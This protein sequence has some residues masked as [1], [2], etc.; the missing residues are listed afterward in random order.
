VQL[1]QPAH[2]DQLA[3]RV[4]LE[5]LEIQVQLDPRDELVHRAH[6]QV[7]QDFEVMHTFTFSHANTYIMFCHVSVCVC[8]KLFA[9]DSLGYSIK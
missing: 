4:L 1:E 3:S 5:I 2:L 7:L 6:S 8:Q 9:I